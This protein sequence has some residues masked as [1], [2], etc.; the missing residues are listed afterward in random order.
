MKFDFTNEQKALEE[1]MNH[2]EPVPEDIYNVQI[3]NIEAKPTRAGGVMLA[4]KE[5]VV[6]GKF[7]NRVFFQNVNV[8]N[9]N[10]VAERIGR[11]TMLKIYVAAGV[12]LKADSAKLV[13]KTITVK[14]V[15]DEYQGVVKNV[16][17]SVVMTKKTE[18]AAADTVVTETQ[19]YDVNESYAF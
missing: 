6:D 19:S 15:Q 14:V 3:E 18:N 16:V 1:Q 9:S 4:I 8:Q 17:K 13:G 11:E 7:K 10:E 2:F 5:R 12:D